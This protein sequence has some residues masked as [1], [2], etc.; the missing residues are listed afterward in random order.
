VWTL[1]PIGFAAPLALA[2][3]AALPV[4]LWLLRSVPPPPRRV[5][6][7]PARLLLGLRDPEQ[8]PQRTPWWLIA[9]R[10]LA[11]ALVI[12]AAAQPLLSPARVGAPLGTLVLAVDDGWASADGWAQRMAAAETALARAEAAG[13][14][15]VLV[16][17]AP[18]PDGRI[19]ALRTDAGGARSRLRAHAPRPWPTDRATAGAALA[20]AV[21]G[22][23]GPVETLWAIDGWTMARVGPSPPAWTAPGLLR[24]SPRWP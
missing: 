24:P 3:L 7:P 9:L 2:A 19:A 11:A 6:F 23:R 5:V 8:T 1:G 17:T 14:R 20:E 22:A 16:F 4:A 18:G 21:R 15:V 13:A 12:L 10:L